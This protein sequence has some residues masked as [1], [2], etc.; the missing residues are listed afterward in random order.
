[1]AILNFI[2][3]GVLPTG[4][5]LLVIG[6]FFSISCSEWF[7]ISF[8][9]SILS[10]SSEESISLRINSFLFLTLE[11]CSLLFFWII[12]IVIISPITFTKILSFFNLEIPLY[13]W[14]FILPSFLSWES[15]SR[16]NSW[17]L[18][19]STGNLILVIVF[20]FTLFNFLFINSALVLNIIL[21]FSA[22]RFSQDK[23][24]EFAENVKINTNKKL[25][26]VLI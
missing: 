19:S 13:N 12:V 23:S 14:I 9:K 21:S 18:K 17:K 25:I 24:W 2:K 16:R 8:S 7:I 3:F 11:R 5:R 26:N 6:L 22:L 10:N 20:F 15:F 1:M 4:S